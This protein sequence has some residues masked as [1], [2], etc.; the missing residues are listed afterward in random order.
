[1][2]ALLFPVVLVLLVSGR[3]TAEVTYERDVRPLLK[4]HCFGCHGEAKELA[5]GLDLR[6]A[7]LIAAGGDSGEAIVSGKS[8]E[9]LLIDYISSGDMP[10]KEELRLSP[11]EVAVIAE[12]VDAGAPTLAAEPRETPTPGE[13]LITDVERS[14]WA[15]LPI[16]SPEIP[17]ASLVAASPEE[18]PGNAIDAF[19]GRR[20]EKSGLDFSVSADRQTLIRRA[21]FDLLGLPPTP[22]EVEAFVNDNSPRAYEDLIDRLLQSPDYGERWGRHWLDAAGYADS[23]GYNDSDLVR[24][25]AWPYRDYVIRS[26]NADKPWDQFI[27]EQLAGDELVGATAANA[28]GLANGDPA[29]L[30]ALTATGFLRMAPDG[31]GSNPM[32]A[33]LARNQAVT[34]TLKVV[35]SA[36]LG[37]SVACAEC[38][39]HRFDPIPQEDFYRMRAIFAPVFDVANWRPPKARRAAILSAADRQRAAEIEAEAKK[40]DAEHT[41][42]KQETL[43]TVFE[44]VLE[45]IPADRRDFAREAFATPQDK[46]TEEQR[47]FCDEEF[48]MLGLLH[49]GRLHLFLARF[50]D[51]EELMKGY[52]DVLAE[53]AKL[54]ATKP[55]PDYI[56]VATEDTKS[57]PE[58]KLFYRGDISSPEG[59]PLQPAGLTVLASFRGAEIPAKEES[60]PTTGRRLAYARYLTS[61]NHPLVARVLVNRFWQHHFGR[62]LVESTGDF[63]RQATE[64]SHPELLDWLAS[65]FMSGGWQLKRLHRLIMTSRTYRQASQRRAEAE[66]IDSENRLL[67]RMPVQRLEAEAVRDAILAAS[68]Q[69]NRTPFGPP[70]EVAVNAGGIIEVAGGTELE[71]HRELK[72]S[73]YVQ[74]RRTQPVAMLDAF[75]A[76]QMEPNCNRRVVSTVATQSLA[77]LNS[78]FVLQQAEALAERIRK[79]ADSDR[80]RRAWLLVYGREPAESER[81]SAEAFLQAQT[82][83]LKTRKIKEPQRAALASLCQVLLGSN[84]FL[85]VD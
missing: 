71:D 23:E 20:L 5:G 84:E 42:L 63:G 48:P 38:H 57:I 50:E 67:W 52:E 55:I 61:G 29:A 79:E 49:P 11:E 28:E 27:V 45:E 43:E 69:L 32:D 76:P 62:G 77:L 54:R 21:T 19:V 13:I 9:S 16:R 41:R 35:S 47:R 15:Y 14:Y 74:V 64:P 2:R 72:R 75:D 1:M 53:A 59:D 46:R 39:H 8:G 65:D 85:Y 7:W 80:V 36:L 18:K 44:R 82:Q 25:G 73:V 51:G 12:W 10:P 70:I 83:D 4:T 68:G 81:Q 78:S 66:A 22:E 26:F 40:L 58:T 37:T 24:D 60:L 17:P 3:A 33:M 34:E 30:E 31:S 56:R 6:L